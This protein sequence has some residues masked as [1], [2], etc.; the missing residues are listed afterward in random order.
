MSLCKK[1]TWKLSKIYL[2]GEKLSCHLYNRHYVLDALKEKNSI[3]REHSER[4][5][6]ARA[7][8]IKGS[9]ILIYKLGEKNEVS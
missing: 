2:V 4:P 6:E 7:I 8:F 3:L 9:S 1:C 5:I